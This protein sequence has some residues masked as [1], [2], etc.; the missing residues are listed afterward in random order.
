MD[1]SLVK[2]WLQ[3]KGVWGGIVATVGGVLG[4]GHYTL[5]T[6]DAAQAVDLITSIISAIGGLYA[7][8]GRVAASHKIVAAPVVAD[9][10]AGGR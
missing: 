4:L 2:G 7:I 6:G 10:Q 8:Y 3:S 9:Q 1:T 5:S